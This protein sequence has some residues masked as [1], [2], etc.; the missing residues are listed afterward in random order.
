MCLD[1]HERWLYYKSQKN[2]ERFHPTLTRDILR[3]QIEIC[4][5][6]HIQVAVYTTIQWDNYT[7]EEVSTFS[8]HYT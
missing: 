1:L 2:P 5:K 3:E 8:V 4:Q 7:A 6:N